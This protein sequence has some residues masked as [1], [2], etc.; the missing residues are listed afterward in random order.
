MNGRLE[1]VLQFRSHS[2]GY[3]WVVMGFLWAVNLLIPLA[4]VSLGVMLPP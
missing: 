2:A 3:G 4:A 1:H